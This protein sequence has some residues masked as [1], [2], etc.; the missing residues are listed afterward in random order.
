MIWIILAALGVPLWIV[1]GVLGAAL[2]SRRRFRARDGVFVCKVRPIPSTGTPKRW[3]RA[4]SYAI[5][6]HDVLLVHAGVALVR[7]QAYPVHEVVRGDDDP[8]M[9]LGRAPAATVVL[10]LDDGA[11]IEVAAPADRRHLLDG[12]SVRRNPEGRHA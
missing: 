4:R 2:W 1:V 3:P 10:R 6:V 8:Q 9:R 12:P 11:T 5:W 7:Y